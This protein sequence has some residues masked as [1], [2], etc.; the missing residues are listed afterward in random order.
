MVT[1]EATEDVVLVMFGATAV[2]GTPPTV[3]TSGGGT[4]EDA[5]LL[6]DVEMVER[7]TD[8]ID[9]EIEMG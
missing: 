7:V 9:C 3:I 5:V 1:M 2:Y 8:A 6:A 4:A